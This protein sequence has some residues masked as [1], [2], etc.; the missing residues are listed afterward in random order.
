MQ[1]FLQRRRGARNRLRPRHDRS[2]QPRR[3]DV[4]PRP[5]RRRRR[6][7]DLR[8]WS[9]TRTSCRGRCSARR[10]APACGSFRSPTPASCGSTSYER[11]LGPSTRIVAVAH[12]SNALGTIN[13]VEA[14][15]RTG[16]RAR[17]PGARRRR[18]GRRAHAGRRAG[19]RLRLLCLLRPQGV[20]PDRHRRAL[21]PRPRCS[22]RCRR[23]RAAAT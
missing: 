19:A 10:R 5:R 6:D 20:R 12:V 1:R 14:I 16:A 15:V 2:D 11:L 8:R 9:I 3:V 7:R 17:D 18:A 22:R 23:I 13:P 4:R 21:R